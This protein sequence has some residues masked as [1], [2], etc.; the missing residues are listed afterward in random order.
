MTHPTENSPHIPDM[1]PDRDS[2]PDPQVKGKHVE[3][4][5]ARSYRFSEA[6]HPLFVNR[7]LDK[8]R[9]MEIEI[10]EVVA[11]SDSV[12]TENMRL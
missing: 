5:S 8:I 6:V 4:D 2:M 7:L 12:K 1:C 9:R 11:L 10:K 3:G